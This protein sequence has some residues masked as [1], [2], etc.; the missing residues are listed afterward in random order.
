MKTF[1][2]LFPLGT[3]R[4][5]LFSY[6]L[7][8]FYGTIT[9]FSTIIQ[10][11]K[12]RQTFFYIKNRVQPPKCLT[13][14][15][16]GEHSFLQLKNLKLHCV[17]N[18]DRNKPLILFLHGFPEFWYSWRYQLPEFGRNYFA[19]AIDM[20]GYGDSDKPKGIIDYSVDK[21]VNDV[22]EVVNTL[23]KDKCILVAHDWGGLV[24]WLTAAQY[25]QMVE[26]L[27]ILNAPHWKYFMESIQSSWKQFFMSWY[28]FFF[29]IPYL[30]ELRLRS[31]DLR[32]I[33]ILFK[34]VANDEE[35]DAYKYNFSKPDGFSGPINYYRAIQRGYGHQFIEKVKSKRITSPTLVIWGKN[36]I[37]LSTSLAHQSCKACDDYSIKI[38][39]D[40]SHW[41]P[42]D[43]PDLVNKYIEEFLNKTN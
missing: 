33:E 17:S 7:A 19:V 9:S 28:I 31:N 16:L 12:R 43:K 35:I 13:D 1:I 26:K 23:G 42:F 25:P 24:G 10:I 18:G 4:G 22:K 2:W 27:I 21:L 5:T 36:D 32:S 15:N 14:K 11:A 8:A 3:F 20:R 34:K 39:D 38:I 30:P 41:T 40:C 29:N 6:S 37:A